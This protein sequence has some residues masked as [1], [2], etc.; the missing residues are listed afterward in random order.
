MEYNKGILEKR[1]SI[2]EQL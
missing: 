1:R 2:C